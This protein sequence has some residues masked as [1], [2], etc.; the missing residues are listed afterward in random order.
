MGDTMSSPTVKAEGIMVPD[1]GSA[2][3][4]GCPMHQDA[5]K[6]KTPVLQYRFFFFTKAIGMQ[7]MIIFD[8]VI[9]F[10]NQIK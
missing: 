10:M 8:N 4:Q 6:S 3:P 1:L 5:N 7:L 2:P 9:Y